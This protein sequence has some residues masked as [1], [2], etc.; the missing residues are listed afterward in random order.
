MP[1]YGRKTN[2][3]VVIVRLIFPR[4]KFT[5]PRDVPTWDKEV[6]CVEGTS[7]INLN[8][9]LSR[10]NPLSH[11]LLTTMYIQPWETNLFGRTEG[12]DMGVFIHTHRHTD[13]HTHTT[14]NT[15]P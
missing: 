2:E 5:N 8:Y 4:L 14:T 13:T 6:F 1:F 11:P 9:S 7:T 3:T 15:H 12:Y 10:H